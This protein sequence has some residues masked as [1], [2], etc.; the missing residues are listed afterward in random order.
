M[1]DASK[2]ALQ[3]YLRVYCVVSVT[4]TFTLEG[5]QTIHRLIAFLTSL[6]FTIPDGGQIA[7]TQY[8]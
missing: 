6:V 1:Q 5:T 8:F 4:E 3:R 7:E 2:I